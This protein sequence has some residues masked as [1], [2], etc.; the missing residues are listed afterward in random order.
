MR[1]ELLI[2]ELAGIIRRLEGR[3]LTEPTYARLLED[4]DQA[5]AHVLKG[6]EDAIAGLVVLHINIRRNHQ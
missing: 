6:I 4:E 1:S 2:G 5:V 3:I